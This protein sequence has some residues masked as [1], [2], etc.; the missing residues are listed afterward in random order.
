MPAAGVWARD[1]AHLNGGELHKRHARWVR[2]VHVERA[3]APARTRNVA[4][5]A[6]VPVPGRPTTTKLVLC[7]TRRHRK[8]WLSRCQRAARYLSERDDVVKESP[9]GPSERISIMRMDLVASNAVMEVGAIRRDSDFQATADG[10]RL[11]G[12]PSGA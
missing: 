12:T 4:Q 5:N 1:D 3:V 9:F 2:R 7:P 8:R 11:E 10:S 6:H